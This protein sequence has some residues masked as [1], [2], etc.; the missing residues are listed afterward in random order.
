MANRV[1][2]AAQFLPFDALKGLKEELQRREEKRSRVEK[3][4][5]TEE[6]AE[7]LSREL[8]KVVKGSKVEMTFY[9]NGHYY[10]LTG[11]V[12]SINVPYR[13]LVIG[14][15]KIFFDNIHT[16]QVIPT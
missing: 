10:D 11:T 1:D 7:E 16:I 4:E 15:E 14:Q 8:M 3:I 12:S 6:L 13:Y 9:Y 2:R 5:L